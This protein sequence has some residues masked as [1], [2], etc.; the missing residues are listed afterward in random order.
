MKDL[1]TI[2][3]PVALDECLEWYDHAE[4][5]KIAHHCSSCHLQPEEFLCVCG[6]VFRRSGDLKHHSRY[7]AADKLF[8]YHCN[9][10][11]GKSKVQ[12]ACVHSCVRACVYAHARTCILTPLFVLLCS[13]PLVFLVD[14]EE[15]HSR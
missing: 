5:R 12:G 1:T 6:R 3:P 14:L 13:E 10:A 15:K 9:Y 2:H 4:W 11:M 7:T 8:R